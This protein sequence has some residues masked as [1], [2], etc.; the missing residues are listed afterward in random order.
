MGQDWLTLFG[1]HREE[2]RPAG[3]ISPSISWHDNI[4]VE[5]N[6]GHRAADEA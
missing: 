5:L 4:L 1:N 3:N 6:N 2:V